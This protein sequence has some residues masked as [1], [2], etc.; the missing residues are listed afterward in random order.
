MHGACHPNDLFNGRAANQ[1]NESA[2][3][4][5]RQ[6]RPFNTAAS[7]TTIEPQT[8]SPFLKS[9]INTISLIKSEELKNCHFLARNSYSLQLLL[10]KKVLWIVRLRN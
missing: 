6:K 10:S 2:I 5:S 7:A 8:E 4:A 3:C 9:K 1:R